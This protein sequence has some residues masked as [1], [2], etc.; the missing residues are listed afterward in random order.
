MR[1]D[2]ALAPLASSRGHAAPVPLA[3]AVPS[4]NYHLWEPCNMRCRF[5]FAT[6]QDIP[7]S[8]LP[9][10]H[11]PEADSL[12]L[13]ERIAAAGFRKL[14]F[15]GGEPTLCKWLDRLIRHAKVC[16]LTTSLVTNGSRLSPEW[17]DRVAGTLDWLTLSVDTADPATSVQLGRAVR[18][19]AMEV[20]DHAVRAAWVRARGI[21]VRLN[22]VVTALT[23]QE[24]L[25][26]LLQAVRPERWKVFQVLPVEG[27]N[28]GRVEDLLVTEAQYRAFVARHE[29]AAE[30][31]GVALVAESNELMTGSYVMI[32]PAGRFFD[33]T[34]GAH[35][36]SRPILEVGVAEALG[37]V[38]VLPERFAARDGLYA[39]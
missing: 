14:N 27:Q 4:V 22:T 3:H 33:N 36:Y 11:L 1:F 12:A 39:W 28:D 30:A 19:Q 10:G 2:T 20:G 34:A 26:P 37:D 38:R 16:G 31:A 29:A 7:R 5:C 6:F 13:I 17:L 35:T 23:W 15:A 9:K 8:V 25:A 32:D 18:G 21:R 24:D